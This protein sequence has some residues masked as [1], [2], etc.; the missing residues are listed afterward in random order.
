MDQK[1]IGSFIVQLRKERNM[2][3]KELAEHLEVTDRAVSKWENGRGMPD[4][5]LM[6]PLCDILGITVSELLNGERIEQ[7][8]YQEKSEFRFLDTI[9][10]T[11]K[12]IKQKN[13]LLRVIAAVTVLLLVA[14]IALIYWLPL[15]RDYF[16]ADGDVEIFHI[17]KTLPI[18]PY[19]E[20]MDRF[21][22][23][24]FAVQDITERI[25][26]EKL[27]DLLPLMRVTVYRED[28]NTS[29]FWQG[30]YIYEI[31]GYFRSG[32]D[33]GETFRI[34]IGDYSRNYLMPH[35]DI[36]VH[37]IQ[38]HNTWLKIMQALEGWEGTHRETLEERPFSLF[39]QGILYSGTGK[40]LDLPAD[41]RQ[42][43][44]ISGVSALPDEE[45][46]CSLGIKGDNIYQWTAGGETYLGV[47]LSYDKAYGIA[48]Q[49]Q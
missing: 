38:E 1:Q 17:R 20:T 35:W 32:P 13:T 5:S 18:M 34:M 46:E 37:T 30:D 39:Y 4:V 28:Y 33:E 47:Q 25:D 36:K 44:S 3:Q 42:I 41:A 16:P 12:K 24:E 7:D 31:Y 23:T 45:G 15:T 11:D 2:T 49:I 29:G 8:D 27:K 26:L 48:A 22:L 14:G 10:Y 43:A 6:K 19:G 21:S 40:L 9:E